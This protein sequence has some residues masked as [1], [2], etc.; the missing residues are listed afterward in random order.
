[1]VRHLQW[2]APGHQN[3]ETG[4]WRETRGSLE[5]GHVRRGTDQYNNNITPLRLPILQHILRGEHCKLCRVQT[6]IRGKINPGTNLDMMSQETRNND[7][8]TTEWSLLLLLQTGVQ[9]WNEK[10]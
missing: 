10:C 6:L 2:S 7:Y 4:D 5:S 8:K 3:T 1:M 9:C